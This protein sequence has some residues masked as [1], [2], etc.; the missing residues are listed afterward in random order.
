MNLFSFLLIGALTFG[1]CFLVD[2]GYTRLFRN[3]QQHRSGLS[4]RVS[5]RYASFGLILCILGILA[6]FTGLSSGTAL[7]IGGVLV[8]LIGCGLIGY[9]LSFGIFYDEDTFILTTFGKKSAT[10]Q[11]RDIR[12]QQLYQIQGGNML[13]ELHLESG[14]SVSVHSGMEGAYPFLDHAFSAWCRQTGRNPGECSFHDPASHLWFP[15][16]EDA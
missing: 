5:K 6:V 7:L 8:F 15:M 10:Y 14:S 2:K 9:Y 3:K 1:I 13:V 4:V 12:H 16:E 11:F